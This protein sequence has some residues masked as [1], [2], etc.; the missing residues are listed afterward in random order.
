MQL[1][2]AC[3]EALLSLAAKQTELEICGVLT[4]QENDRIDGFS[5]FPGPL[6]ANRFALDPEWQLHEYQR[7]RREGRRVLGYYHSHPG[8]SKLEPS[9]RDHA[10][11]PPGS[12]LLLLSTDG[13]WRAFRKPLARKQFSLA[14]VFLVEGPNYS[15][16][17]SSTV[18]ER[19]LP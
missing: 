18:V 17:P 2:R 9:D 5:R 1:A 12:F 10:D 19:D 15:P 6:Y 8:A 3:L 11:H 16:R 14:R 4:G 7:I 13:R